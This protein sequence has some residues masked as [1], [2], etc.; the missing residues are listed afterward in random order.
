MLRHELI[1]RRHAEK[2]VD[3]PF[4][5]ADQFQ[6]GAGIEGAHRAEQP[7]AA[8]DDVVRRPAVEGPDRDDRRFDRIDVA[9]DD[10]LHRND[11]LRGDK[12]G[13]DREVRRGT[14]TAFPLDRDLDRVA[15]RVEQPFAKPDLADRLR[16]GEVQAVGALDAEPLEHAVLDHRFRPAFAFFGGLEQEADGTGDVGAP[17]GDDARGAE[18]HRDVTVVA[19]GVHVHRRARAI[20]DVVLLVERQCVHVGPQ[21]DRLPGPRS[22]QHADD[23]GLADPG[24]H[25]VPQRQQ[26]IGDERRGAIFFETELG[27]L[28]QVAPRRDD[29]VD[30]VGRNVDRQ[31]RGRH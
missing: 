22:A 7:D 10:L 31:G 19:A 6:R 16:R 1:D 8:R 15:R 24:M 13:I 17:P 27:M 29:F 14:V 21:H 23:A 2:A 18:Q 30:D 20:R 9:R 26:P 3:A 11:E 25:L 5:I 4:G 12:D 28:V